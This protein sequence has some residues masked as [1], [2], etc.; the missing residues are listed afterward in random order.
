MIRLEHANMTVQ[1]IDEVQ[2]FLQTAFPDFRVR[3]EGSV[4]LPDCT[5]R[6]MHLGNDHQY[7]AL[8]ELNLHQKDQRDSYRDIG[9]NHLGFVVE[10]LAPVV[11][12]LVSKGYRQGHLHAESRYRRRVYFFDKTGFEWEFVEYKSADPKLRNDYSPERPL[13]QIS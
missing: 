4:D 9:I 7:I 2:D 3:H 6:W 13:S 10:D 8:E 12:R 1:S 5:K 11:A